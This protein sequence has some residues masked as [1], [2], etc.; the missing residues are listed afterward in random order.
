MYM[1]YDDTNVN[2]FKNFGRG[3]DDYNDPV[4]VNPLIVN[5]YWSGYSMNAEAR[6]FDNVIAR[7]TGGPDDSLQKTS[8]CRI[9][10]IQKISV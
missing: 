6:W 3:L 4:R 5:K 9:F 10:R 1:G 2:F 8:G 7:Q